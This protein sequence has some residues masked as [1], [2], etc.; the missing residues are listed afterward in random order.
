MCGHASIQYRFLL[1]LALAFCERIG[2]IAYVCDHAIFGVWSME[3]GSFSG[4]DGSG[5]PEDE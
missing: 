2:H 5:V 1:G 4:V 3:V